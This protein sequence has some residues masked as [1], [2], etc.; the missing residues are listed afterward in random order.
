MLNT[1]RCAN[2]EE[3]GMKAA[4]LIASEIRQAKKQVSIAFPGGNS[5]VPLLN[6]LAGAEIQW[7][8]VNAFM[9]DERLVPITDAQSNYTQAHELLFSKAQGIHAFP[10][11]M[12]KGA[13]EYSRQFMAVT[14]G[15]LDILVLGV[16]E[17]GHIASLFPHSPALK[18]GDPASI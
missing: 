16:G 3:I 15:K 1:T 7:P 6:A 17:D 5:V 8:L 11:D 18:S 12:K 4:G 13:G 14:K 10:F 9:A 2:P